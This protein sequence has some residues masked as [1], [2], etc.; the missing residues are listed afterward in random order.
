MKELDKANYPYLMDR[1]LMGK[2]QKQMYGTQF[3]YDEKLKK[4]SL[5]PIE[6]PIRIDERRAAYHLL[7]LK[8][9]IEFYKNIYERLGK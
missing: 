1:I 4:V 3:S 2:G 5:Y 7:P 9:D 6:D 8:Y